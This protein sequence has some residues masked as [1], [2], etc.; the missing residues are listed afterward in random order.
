MGSLFCRQPNTAWRHLARTSRPPKSVF[1]MSRTAGMSISKKG[2]SN[3]NKI[4]SVD[5][6]RGWDS[7]WAW[8]SPV[9]LVKT[10]ILEYPWQ[11]VAKKTTM[12]LKSGKNRMLEAEVSLGRLHDPACIVNFW[13]DHGIV[14]PS[15]SGLSSDPGSSSRRSSVLLRVIDSYCSSK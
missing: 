1:A 12:E 14:K 7:G 6:T 2:A 9:S 5:T 11:A 3:P 13:C 4:I 10:H 8:L 15:H